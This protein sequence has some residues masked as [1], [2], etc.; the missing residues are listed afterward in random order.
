MAGLGATPPIGRRTFLQAAGGAFAASLLPG[1]AEALETAD[2]VFATAFRDRSG[3]FG[4]ALMSEDGAIVHRY[5]LPERGHDLVRQPGGTV[6]VAFARRPGT[7]AA[8]IDLSRRAEPAI[9]AAA[10]GRHFY[11]HGA[12]SADGRL[13]FAT[14][15]DF[16]AARGVIGIYDAIGGFA[17][18]GE[19]GTFGTGP[20]DMALMPDGRTLVVANGGIETHP[21]Y[22]RAKLNVPTMAPN[23]A[24]VDIGTGDLIARHELP[25][26]LHKLSIRHLTLDR[27]GTVWFAC[28]NQGDIAEPIPL[29]GRATPSSGKFGLIELLRAETASLRGYVGSIAAN[30]E[31]GLIAITSPRGGV[32]HEIEPASGRV[33]R[34][35]RR[36]DVCGVAPSSGGFTFSSGEGAFADRHHV[37]GFD[38][39][40]ARVGRT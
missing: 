36:A 8:I 11:G 26:S 39:H 24:F 6:L 25:A 13:L 33:L 37:I 21:D 16:D 3:S 18:I 5:A 2:A 28:Q 14:E 29:I 23:L 1:A 9:I 32:A 12:F 30:T 15:N 38:N 10:G 7:F 35:V 40:I 20:H 34:S 19:F 4:I 31:T 27:D 17:R 22:P